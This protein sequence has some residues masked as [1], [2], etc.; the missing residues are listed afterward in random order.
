[1][2]VYFNQVAIFLLLHISQGPAAPLLHSE[3][4]LVYAT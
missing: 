1:M 3:G 4:P 2:M